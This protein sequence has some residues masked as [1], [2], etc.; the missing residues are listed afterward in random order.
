LRTVV[1]GPRNPT[2]IQSA[3]DGTGRLFIVQQQGRIYILR[4]G[5]VEPVPF[6][7]ISDRTVGA[8][9]RGLLGLAFPPGFTAS[10]R[11][12]V[13]YTDRAGNTVIAM[14]RVSADLNVADRDSET[15]LLQIQQPFSNHNGG[16]LRFGPDGM[17][18]I[19]TGDGGSAGDPRNNA[20]SLASLLGKMLR[21]DVESQP[22]RAL[23]PPDNPFAAA[24]SPTTRP[25]IWSYGLRN[26][27]RFS[28]DRLTGDVWMGDV[29]QDAFEEVNYSPRSSR[30][31]E[32]YGWNPKEGKS[33]FLRNCSSEGLVDPVVD[34]P[35]S[36]GCSVTGG[37]VYR[38]D[39]S[40]GLRGTFFYGDFCSGRMWGV[41]REGSAWVNRAVATGAGAISTFGEDEDG[42]IYVADHATGRIS[43]I[44]GRAAPE[45][46][47]ALNPATFEDG[48]VPGSLADIY[49][50]GV[51]AES[52]VGGGDGA[53]VTINGTPALVIATANVNGLEFVRVQ[54]PFEVSGVN[55]S[56]AVT[57]DG[58]TGAAASFPLRALQPG[59]FSEFGVALAV[60]HATNTLVT[61][62]APASA[63]EILYF[64]ANGLGPV[65][66][67]R[68]LGEVRVTVDGIECELFYAGVA[69]G[70]PGVYQINIR[71]PGGLTAGRRNLRIAIDGLA[72]PVVEIAVR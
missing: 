46:V 69:P 62:A 39:R 48:L 47:A 50:Y 55:A 63:G 27:W 23:V 1:T 4:G 10:G 20:Q 5:F 37:Y 38:G 31:G 57:K 65:A 53:A 26:P 25:E 28:F 19:A 66:D 43:R 54:V 59:V 52:G 8:G 34:Y 64:Y 70:F 16:A 33:C 49:A 2:D 35:H 22:G 12:Y 29:G 67:S 72:S 13:N 61:D 40:P 56:V 7:D 41:R 71:L 36:Q 15:V 30:G 14:Y 32:N 18:W 42:E 11:F 60:H 21:L 58:R 24:A 44:E 17:L 6:L 68:T 9:E 51:R 45:V 3:R